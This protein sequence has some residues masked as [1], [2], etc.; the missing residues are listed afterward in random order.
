MITK[1][2]I[3]DIPHDLYKIPIS[4]LP[5][6]SFDF[7]ISEYGSFTIITRNFIGSTVFFTIKINNEPLCVNNLA[8]LG[9]NLSY[10]PILT[11][12]KLQHGFFLLTKDD[13]LREVSYYDLGNKVSL[14][15][16]PLP[17]QDP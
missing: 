16:T 4:P 2:L 3:T 12:D 13:N 11:L 17:Y 9:V 10:A 8:R 7:T 1:T 14:Y 6:Q 15:Y 5:N